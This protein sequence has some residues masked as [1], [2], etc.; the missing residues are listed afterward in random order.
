MSR[1]GT[2][3][4]T[5][6]CSTSCSIGSIAEHRRGP[7]VRT[8]SSANEF[9][10]TVRAGRHPDIGTTPGV[11]DRRGEESRPQAA[12]AGRV[13]PAWGRPTICSNSRARRR[14]GSA[15]PPKKMKTRS[16]GSRSHSRKR[17]SSPAEIG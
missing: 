13:A 4:G 14:E 3:P 7:R 12:A 5:R 9:V 10:S 11:H 2:A 6:P 15:A 8:H 17:G 16:P 1:R